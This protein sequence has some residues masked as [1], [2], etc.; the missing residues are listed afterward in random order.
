MVALV[1]SMYL[2]SELITKSMTGFAEKE[3]T[4]T[5]IFHSMRLMR[6][7]LYYKSIIELVQRYYTIWITSTII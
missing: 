1:L 3:K 5:Y 7:Y 2:L 4:S 6:A